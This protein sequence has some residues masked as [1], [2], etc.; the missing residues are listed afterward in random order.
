MPGSIP[1]PASSLGS[2][3]PNLQALAR[4][5]IAFNFQTSARIYILLSAEVESYNLILSLLC[6]SNLQAQPSYNGTQ[7]RKPPQF[8]P[9]M[10]PIQSPD[11]GCMPYLLPWPTLVST[12]SHPKVLYLEHPHPLYQT[13]PCTHLTLS[14]PHH[15]Q[16]SG[17]PCPINA[18]L[19]SRVLCHF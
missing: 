11:L 5:Y 18:G 7:S 13:S 4:I 9:N 15:I 1:G 17:L 14:H 8:L 19:C 3:T 12:G 2:T 16:P 10:N 6:Q